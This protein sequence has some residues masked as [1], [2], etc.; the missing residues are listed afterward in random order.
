VDNTLIDDSRPVDAASVRSSEHSENGMRVDSNAGV[1]AS[2]PVVYPPS[3]LGR[4]GISYELGGP[5]MIPGGMPSGVPASVYRTPMDALNHQ[6]MNRNVMSSVYG[7]IMQY[8]PELFSPIDSAYYTAPNT[9]TCMRVRQ[10]NWSTEATPGNSQSQNGLSLSQDRNE[11]DGET[12]SGNPSGNSR[13]QREQLGGGQVSTSRPAPTSAETGNKKSMRYAS[14]D[15]DGQVFLFVSS[16]SDVPDAD[17][18][19]QVSSHK[20]SE[21]SRNKGDKSA[22]K[23]ESSRNKNEN[24]ANRKSA[25]QTETTRKSSKKQAVSSE[26]VSKDERGR[27][28]CKKRH[29][30]SRLSSESRSPSSDKGQKGG[31]DRSEKLSE[32]LP[33]SSRKKS[34]GPVPN[35]DKVV[36]ATSSDDSSSESENDGSGRANIET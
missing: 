10:P 15:D 5:G 4:Q 35:G 32:A 31:R 25:E 34:Q 30:R 3:E 33:S 6:Q 23:R 26:K 21:S 8:S 36:P 20:Q 7:N 14:F 29:R 9:C 18:N 11:A 22:K 27:S 19:R 1:H 2:V 28:A 13:S 16:D 17:A 24:S 12:G